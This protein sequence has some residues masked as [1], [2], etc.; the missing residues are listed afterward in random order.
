[1][2][3]R[4]AVIR[5]VCKS[6]AE[7][8]AQKDEITTRIRNLKNERIKGDLGMKVSDFNT[9]YRWYLL[10]QDD[11]DTLI[12]T[13]R[14]CFEALGVG[15]QLSFVAAMEHEQEERAS[16]ST[17]RGEVAAGVDAGGRDAA[18][19]SGRGNGATASKR[20]EDAE[21]AAQ[22]D[23]PVKAGDVFAEGDRAGKA[24]RK[25]KDNPYK[26]NG[27][28]SGRALDA[29]IWERGRKAGMKFKKAVDAGEIDEA[30]TLEYPGDNLG[31]TRPEFPA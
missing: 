23:V 4:H 5:D 20:W 28:N 17:K 16:G 24:G 3:N 26:P 2:T 19:R 18:I 22:Q 27:S 12:D 10:E 31:N 13:M 29:V 1:M 11:R 9:A 30:V 14:E 7:L 6:L 21:P 15:E 8:Q 25:A